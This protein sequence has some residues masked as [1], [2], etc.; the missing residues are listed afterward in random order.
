MPIKE[1]R[2]Q[3]SCMD[4]GGDDVALPRRGAAID[5]VTASTEHELRSRRQDQCG[6]RICNIDTGHD[7]RLRLGT[8][9]VVIHQTINAISIGTAMIP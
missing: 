9:A 6:A 2:A 5:S 8:F 3:R 1:L 7:Q 4:Q